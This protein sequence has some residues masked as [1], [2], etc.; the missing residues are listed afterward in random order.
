MFQLSFLIEDPI[1]ISV[2]MR[3]SIGTLRDKAAVSEGG[4]GGEA[5]ASFALARPLR[6]YHATASS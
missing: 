1:E 3:E 4:E 6:L 5:M 2:E